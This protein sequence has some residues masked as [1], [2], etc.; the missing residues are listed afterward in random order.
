MLGRPDI[1]ER[2]EEQEDQQAT[3]LA[4]SAATRPSNPCGHFSDASSLRKKERGFLNKN[5]RLN[6][7]NY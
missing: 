6:L 7:I 3:S 2:E 5:F 4:G 1:E